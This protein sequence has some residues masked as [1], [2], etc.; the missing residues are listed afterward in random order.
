MNPIKKYK[1]GI[2]V[3]NLLNNDNT[4]K[5]LEEII[6]KPQYD[7][8]IFTLSKEGMVPNPLTIFNIVDYF[9]WQDISI[10]TSYQTLEKSLIYPSPGPKII[11][12]MMKYENYITIPTFNLDLINEAVDGFYKNDSK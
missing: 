9:S 4:K 11:I 8:T 3:D 7:C 5:I 12:G 10:I 2:L 1:F 6:N